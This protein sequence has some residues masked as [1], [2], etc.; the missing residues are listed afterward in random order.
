[1]AGLFER[2]QIDKFKPLV[3]SIFTPPGFYVAL[4]SHVILVMEAKY[5]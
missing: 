3:A 4:N 2:V 1:M 5:V